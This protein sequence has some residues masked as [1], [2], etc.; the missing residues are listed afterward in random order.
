MT[1]EHDA[2]PLISRV[3]SLGLWLHD[4]GFSYQLAPLTA[5]VLA[6][7]GS[8]LTRHFAFKKKAKKR[9]APLKM[10]SKSELDFNKLPFEPCIVHFGAAVW[11]I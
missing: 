6:K 7:T 3:A 10:T 8:A 1:K 11:E 5:G 9:T 2:R 4:S